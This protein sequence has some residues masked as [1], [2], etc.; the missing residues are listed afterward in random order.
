M[1]PALKIPTPVSPP[2]PILHLTFPS[3]TPKQR[4]ERYHLPLGFVQQY[5]YRYR[6]PSPSPSVSPSCPQSP[7]LSPSNPVFPSQSQSLS[8]FPTSPSPSSL[9]LPSPGRL[10]PPLGAP[11]SAQFSSSSSSSIISSPFGGLTARMSPGSYCQQLGGSISALRSS[12]PYQEKH[13][14]RHLTIPE[15]VVCGLEQST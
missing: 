14:P 7:F 3:A 1:L 15:L 13:S 12:L 11:G 5:I 6:F 4:H 8:H 10:L 9:S 2:C